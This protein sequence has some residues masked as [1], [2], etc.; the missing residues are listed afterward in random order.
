MSNV[1][2]IPVAVFLVFQ[3]SFVGTYIAA[4]LQG[5]VVPTVPYIS[6]AATYSPESCVFGQMI[7]LGSV[8]L[9]ITVYVRYR[10]IL[11][12]FEHHSDLGNNLLRYNRL[13]VW[14]GWS[15]CLGISI[16]GNFQET[17]VRIV[18]FTGAFLCFGFGALYFWLQSLI[19]YMIYPIA[20]TKRNAHLRLA[21][22]AC[23]TM[24][25]I[26]MAVTGVMS[27]ILFR[28]QNP[29]KWYPSDGGWHFH[30]ISSISEW[31][32]ATIF[33]FYILTFT[34]E[35]RDLDIDHPQL[36]LISYSLTLT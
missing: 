28:G 19:S 22:A 34:E 8:L 26:L 36:R 11:Q 7:N 32:M 20:G 5:H 10:Q 33:S 9:G 21:M 23:C 16:V 27:H 13:A 29:R 3:V 14:F 4:V 18:H 24:L 2:L 31:I 25:F 1:Y 30:V 35:F 6:D 15:S 12:L 17:N